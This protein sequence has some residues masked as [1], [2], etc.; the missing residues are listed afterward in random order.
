MANAAKPKTKGNMGKTDMDR[1]SYDTFS[2]N[3]SMRKTGRVG[4]AK[5]TPNSNTEDGNK[6]RVN[7]PRFA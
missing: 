6:R 4:G 2:A 7:D 1:G 3:R 5:M